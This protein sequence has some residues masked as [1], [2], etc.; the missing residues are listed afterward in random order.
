M[1]NHDLISYVPGTWMTAVYSSDHG[2]DCGAPVSMADIS[3]P[4]Q[5]SVK[6]SGYSDTKRNRR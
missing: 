4:K 6:N 1:S 5:R 3:S 2:L